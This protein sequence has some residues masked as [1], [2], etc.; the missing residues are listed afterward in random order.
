MPWHPKTASTTAP[1]TAERQSFLDNL[2]TDLRR[3]RLSNDPTKWEFSG[4][5][6]DTKV[7]LAFERLARASITMSA[8]MVAIG[9]EADMPFCTAY[10]RY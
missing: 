6:T 9:G 10:V 7:A 8:F 1:N 4:S 2:V 5:V 3:V